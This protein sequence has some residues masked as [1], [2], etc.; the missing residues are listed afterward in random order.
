MLI[1][2]FIIRTRLYRISQTIINKKERLE[3]SAVLCYSDDKKTAITKNYRKL[4]LYSNLK[5][6]F[7]DFFYSVLSPPEVIFFWVNIFNLYIHKNTDLSWKKK[8]IDPFTTLKLCFKQY[9]FFFFFK[10]DSIFFL[11]KIY[12][13]QTL[14]FSN[15]VFFFIFQNQTLFFFKSHLKKKL[16]WKKN[17]PYINFFH[18]WN[19]NLLE[20]K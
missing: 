14:I 8:Q 19:K 10:A 2:V 17:N 15:N 6:C 18:V 16:I 9:I 3:F 12:F 7:I 5:K 20:G 1:T 13:S 11:R 4:Y